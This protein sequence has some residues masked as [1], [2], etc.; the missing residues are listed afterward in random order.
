M[1]TARDLIKGSMRLIGALAAG[2]TPSA[3]EQADALLSLNDMLDSWSSDKLFIFKKVREEFSLVSGQQSR[4]MGTGANF[5]TSKP[6]FIEE[7]M[8]EEQSSGNY[9]ETPLQMLS[10][11]EW[12]QVSPKSQ[13][14]DVPQLLFVE[15]THPTLTL[16]FWPT[17][18]STNKAVLHSLKPL[19][20]FSSV[21]DDVD[22]PP[23][24]AE[25]L[26]YNLAL[27]L[28]PEYG[29]TATNEILMIAADGMEKI[30]RRNSG[31]TLM[32]F[33]PALAGG[34]RYNIY[35]GE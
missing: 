4:T 31:P 18:S 1:S 9:L 20:A 7:A 6:A 16:Y 14:A 28:C 24:Y 29:K 8:I 34:A 2:E 19:T 30:Q 13:T 32:S 15:D 33:D 25:A 35:T 11:Q 27:R 17:P 5:N 26:K 22:L 23:G 10:V 12:A 21:S 3:D